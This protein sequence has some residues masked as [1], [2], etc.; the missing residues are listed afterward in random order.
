M[1]VRQVVLIIGNG[2]LVAQLNTRIDSGCQPSTT[3]RFGQTID[4]IVVVDGS[5]S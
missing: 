3:N 5:V 2:A 4:L 1:Q